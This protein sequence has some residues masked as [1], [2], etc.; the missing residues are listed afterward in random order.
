MLARYR[1]TMKILHCITGLS[2]DGAQR[3]LLRLAAAMAD[4]GL[5]SKV[6]NLGT[7]T[8]LREEFEQSG[9][10]V[11]SL[12]MMP[13]LGCVPAGVRRLRSEINIFQPHIVQGWMYHA[14]LMLT[15]ARIGRNDSAKMLW[16]VRRGLDDLSRRGKKTQFVIKANRGLSRWSDG[17]LYCSRESKQ[18][19]EDFGFCDLHSH[20]VENGFDTNRFSFSEVAR[21]AV[22][23]QLGI[24]DN[25]LVIGCIARYDI[26][27]GH[28][29]LI[30]AFAELINEG[31][32]V[33][34]ILVGRGVTEQNHE[35][36]EALSALG[37]INRVYLLGERR[38]IE[39]IYSALDIYCS[40]SINEGFP[41]VISEA[42][43]VGIPCVV[44]DTGA[45]RRLV[46]DSGRVVEPG[47]VGPL[48][49][50]LKELLVMS[51]RERCTLGQRS[52]QLISTQYGLERAVSRYSGIYHKI[53]ESS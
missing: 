3:M 14:N 26:A 10:P 4:R 50:A 52:R 24:S 48:K 53:L 18:Q 13:S 47:R 21:K 8:N 31:C 45:S 22:R 30:K 2:G 5:T 37:L 11:V 33:K 44:T 23:E 16:N 15:L 34:L 51:T 27:K 32:D 7:S 29:F 20:V 28:M 42:M 35:I 1:P 36:I 12:D 25:D 46:T 40:P 39:N 38:D 41:N 17:I 43:S 49:G 9:I 6:I 19:H